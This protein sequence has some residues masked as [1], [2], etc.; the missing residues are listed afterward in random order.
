MIELRISGESITIEGVLSLLFK[1]NVDASV[2]STT[3]IVKDEI[4][5]RHIE[6]GVHVLMPE[7][8]HED[9][10]ETVW[11]SLRDTFSLRCGWM[12]ASTKSYR[13]C[14]ENYMKLDA[15]PYKKP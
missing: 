2:S 1:L 5:R 14:T 8:S 10:R 3:N 6:A 13:G 11:P 7:C 9:F 4:G 12:D 15:C